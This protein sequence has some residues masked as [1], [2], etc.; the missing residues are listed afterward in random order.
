M[1]RVIVAATP[2]AGHTSP[3]IQIAAALV[4]AGRDVVFVGGERYASQ[5]KAPAPSSSR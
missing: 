4:T 2:L 3:M 1:S 5:V